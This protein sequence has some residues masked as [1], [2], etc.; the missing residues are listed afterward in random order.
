[1][2]ESYKSSRREVMDY[3]KYCELIQLYSTNSNQSDYII[4]FYT[5]DSKVKDITVTLT[6]NKK[7]DNKFEQL[8][9]ETSNDYTYLS[10]T[11]NAFLI[12]N[13][14]ISY[15]VVYDDCSN[16]STLTIYKKLLNGARLRV[17]LKTSKDRKYLEKLAEL[18]IHED[19]K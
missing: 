13:R 15:D 19:K 1:M 17:L 7:V 12:E 4:D 16:G 6:I 18:F 5:L 11:V 3:C 14:M 2:S 10:N 9:S 8:V